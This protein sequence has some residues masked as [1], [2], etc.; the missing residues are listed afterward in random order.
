MFCEQHPKKQWPHFKLWAAPLF[1]PI[2][3][4]QG[5]WRKSV[6]PRLDFSCAGPGMPCQTCG[7]GMFKGQD[8]KCARPGMWT[9]W[10]GVIVVDK[11]KGT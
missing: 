10:S 3:K 4:H 6:W 2:I 8:C 5:R 1:F 9:D 7:G 11:Q